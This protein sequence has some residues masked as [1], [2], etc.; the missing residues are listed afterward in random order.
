MGFSIQFFMCSCI[1][2]FSKV[3]AST[4]NEC[5]PVF[6]LLTIHVALFWIPSAI[7]YLE[8]ALNLKHHLSS[9]SCLWANCG[10]WSKWY[11][12]FQILY[13]DLKLP[14]NGDPSLGQMRSIRSTTNRLRNFKAA[15]SCGKD[16]LIKLKAYHDLPNVIMEWRKLN[17]TLTKVGKP[18]SNS[19]S[20]RFSCDTFCLKVA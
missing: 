4:K 13:Q 18:F 20:L 12:F 15:P 3:C 9:A 17:M 1:C 6:F 2:S 5:I 7:S 10:L 8:K 19:F 11:S 16:I 14:L